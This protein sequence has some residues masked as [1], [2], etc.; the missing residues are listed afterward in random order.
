MDT[1]R[2]IRVA[3]HAQRIKG[4]DPFRWR[5]YVGR[6][7]PEVP[8]RDV[9][10]LGDVTPMNVRF[11]TEPSGDHLG[12]VAWID[13]FGTLEIRDDVALVTVAHVPRP[14]DA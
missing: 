4:G 11:G 8:L 10:I 2:W 12:L 3:G 13:L 6:E 9:H 7:P 5:C 14:E 1:P